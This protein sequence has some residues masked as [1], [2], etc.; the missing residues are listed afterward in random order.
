MRWSKLTTLAIGALIVATT[1]VSGCKDTKSCS[2]EN[3]NKQKCE[4]QKRG[5]R[6]ESNALYKINENLTTRWASRENPNALKGEGA[7]V[8][9]GAKGEPY[10]VLGPN[11]QFTMLD[12]EGA[13]II[14]RIW[15]TVDDL[16]HIPEEWRCLKVEMFWDGAETPAV[17]APLEDFFCQPLGR[18]VKMENALFASPE[19]RSAI[20][21]IPMPFRKGAKI[22]VT[23]ESQKRSHRVFFDVN[24]SSMDK[25]DEDALYFHAHWR[26]EAPTKLGKDFTIMPSVSGKGRFLGCNIGVVRDQRYIGWWGE[27]E[28]KIFL[29][30][31]KEHP[32]LCGTG[33][34]D[35]IGT[36]WG[37]GFFINRYHGSHLVDDKRGLNGFYRFHIPDPVQFKKD[38]KVTIHQLGGCKKA[39]VKQMMADGLPA[40]AVAVIHPSKVQH[41]LLDN[42][43]YTLDDK[44]FSD[45][46]FTVFYRE[47]DLC[48]TSYFYL[49]SPTNN[50]PPLADFTARNANLRGEKKKK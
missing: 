29:D 2:C 19:G 4:K 48:A 27:G 26:R 17:S 42:N 20:C 44:E 12:V 6:M 40:Q 35:Y 1:I 28:V 16:Y 34:E 32:S 13:G 37:Q 25:I 43:D 18:N 3:G 39:D 8:N 45:A 31:D 14:H 15:L 22:V 21:Y 24:F 38:C 46:I 7:K 9:K 23:N 5:K 50:L 10:I 36:G 49:D 47:D 11:Q 33:T 41:N 30:G